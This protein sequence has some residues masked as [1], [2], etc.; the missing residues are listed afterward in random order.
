MTHRGLLSGGE[1]ILMEEHGT[2]GKKS[3][4]LTVSGEEAGLKVIGLLER[5]F[6]LPKSLLHRWIRTGQVR[7]NGGR[8]QP[9]A[10]VEEGDTVRV[11]P[12]AE[13]MAGEAGETKAAVQDL[14][15][16]PIIGEKDGLVAVF[17]PAGLPTQ[18]GTG[19]EDSASERL[20]AMS[21]IPLFPSLRRTGST[22]TRRESCSAAGLSRPSRGPRN[23]SAIMTGSARNT[24]PGL[25]GNG[26]TEASTCSGTTSQSALWAATRK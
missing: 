4:G 20:R 9:F 24:S 18:P 6:G 17:K 25:R 22:G 1:D 16:L 21:G 23:S 5:H 11:P 7:V 2:D 8:V 13:A 10:R 12:F 14:P 19:H 15:E 3:G 26:R